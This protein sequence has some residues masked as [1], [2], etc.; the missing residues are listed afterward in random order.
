MDLRE[1][2]EWKLMN[3]K[4]A[5]EEY[6]RGCRDGWELAKKVINIFFKHRMSR[7]YFHQAFELEFPDSGI[8]MSFNYLKVFNDY[9]FSDVREVMKKYESDPHVG[10][11]VKDVH[12]DTYY[13]CWV[14]KEEKVAAVCKNGKMLMAKWG[15][16]TKT[17]YFLDSIA[18]HL[19]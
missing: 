9:S 1:S 18:E 17:G 10:D 2:E 3:M 12:G 14:N 8:G 19:G 15:N 11:E 7:E 5:E 4:D 13:V 6:K 16:L